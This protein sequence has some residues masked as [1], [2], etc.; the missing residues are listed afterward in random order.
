[1]IQDVAVNSRNGLLRENHT[2]QGQVLALGTDLWED[3]LNL[4]L[5]YS[6]RASVPWPE[7]RSAAGVPVEEGTRSMPPFRHLRDA[8]EERTFKFGRPVPIA[9]RVPLLAA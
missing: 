4:Y 7:H 6:R 5:P 1:M 2:P 3:A 8:D 9:V